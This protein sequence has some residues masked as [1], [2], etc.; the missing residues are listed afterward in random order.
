MRLAL[1]P[2]LSLAPLVGSA[3]FQPVSA[4]SRQHRP[5]EGPPPEDV[6][7]SSGNLTLGGLWFAPG[8]EGPFPAAVFIRGSGPSRRDS[9]WGR[10]FVDLLVSTGIAV[11]LPDKRGSDASE[12]DWR[13]AGFDDLAGDALAGVAFA[14]SRPE[15]DGR[16]VGLVGLSQGGKI[17]PIAAS[18]SEDVAFVVDVVGAATTLAE[19]VSWEMYHTFREAG[20]SGPALQEGLALQ[21]L[22]EA[23]LEGAAD[24]SAYETARSAALAGPGA[25]VARG[26]PATPDA[27]QWAFF[28]RVKDHDP[29]PYWRDVTQPV[30]VLYGED[31]HNA[32]SIRSAYRL[33]RLWREIGHPDATVRVIPDAGHPLWDPESDPHRPALHPMVVSTVR[34]WLRARTTPGPAGE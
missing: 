24:W 18:R 9:Y 29:L 26:F 32:P 17:A 28:R 20:V 25:E 22:A 23:Y 33:L 34:D 4:W 3:A 14:R 27:W 1:V 31:D 11:L 8:G 10:A 16:P 13:T 7:F 19:Q 6:R 21:V 5:P 2:V 30:L 15:V 12:G